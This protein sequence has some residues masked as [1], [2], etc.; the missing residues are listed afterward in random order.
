MGVSSIPAFLT[1]FCDDLGDEFSSSDVSVFSGEVPVEERGNIYVQV[2]DGP[3]EAAAE[4]PNIDDLVCE[5]SYDVPCTIAVLI[6][7]GGEETA[8]EARDKAFDILDTVHH[9]LSGN[10]TAMGSVENVS[11]AGWTVSQGAV[12]EG[13]ACRIAFVVRVTARFVPA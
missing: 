4:Y 5:E 3:I 11:L 13:R 2:G 1:A 9:Q 12:L 7:G 8:L 10:D 6:P